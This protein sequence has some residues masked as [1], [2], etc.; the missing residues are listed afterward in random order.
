LALEAIG[1]VTK[2]VDLN[3][4][5]LITTSEDASCYVESIGSIQRFARETVRKLS[6]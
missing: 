1:N 4:L 6:C 3:S 2:D 5:S